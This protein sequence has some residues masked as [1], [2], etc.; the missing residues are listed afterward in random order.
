MV[1]VTIMKL[2]F[3]SHSTNISAVIYFSIMIKHYVMHN[4]HICILVFFCRDGRQLYDL[5]S[6]TY[7]V[8]HSYEKNFICFT[9]E[10]ECTFVAVY[11]H[12]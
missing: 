5:L 9:V 11:I 10:T 8:S 4:Y 3:E 1:P 7:D 2:K 12:L 6:K